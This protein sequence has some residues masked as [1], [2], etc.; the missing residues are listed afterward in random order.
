[1]RKVASRGPKDR[2]V[3]DTDAPDLRGPDEPAIV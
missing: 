2:L 3:G 1:M